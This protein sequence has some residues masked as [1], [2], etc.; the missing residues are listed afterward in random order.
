V[1]M[2]SAPHTSAQR[3][4]PDSTSFAAVMSA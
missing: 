4:A 1:L 2:R 3:S